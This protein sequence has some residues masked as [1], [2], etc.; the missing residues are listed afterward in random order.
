[1]KQQSQSPS[2][3]LLP[4]PYMAD[5]LWYFHIIAAQLPMPLIL[6]SDASASTP[7]SPSTLQGRFDIITA[8]P[9]Y[10]LETDNGQVSWRGQ[11]VPEWNPEGMDSFSA[12][13]KLVDQ[14]QRTNIDYALCAK[15]ELP[16]CGGLIGYCSYDLAREYI[17]LEKISSG[18]I[19]IPDM[20]FGFY[21][22]AFIQ[23]HLQKQ[24]CLV[25]HPS[26]ASTTR[27]TVL[28]IITGENNFSIL[29]DIKK[30]KLEKSM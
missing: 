25:I 6:Q 10:W 21:G 4:L 8:A 19:A 3:S 23:D 30:I 15:K 14:I 9:E 24:S 1:M 27:N 16:F 26:C 29:P 22:W 13:H 12:L 2:P 5:S 17:P 20:Q 7:D 18:N 11:K 28:K